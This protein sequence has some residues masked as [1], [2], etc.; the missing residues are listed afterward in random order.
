MSASTTK[1][2]SSIFKHYSSSKEGIAFIRM[3][4]SGLLITANKAISKFGKNNIST[5]DKCAVREDLQELV[6][7]LNNNND[8][9]RKTKRDI[10]QKSNRILKKVQ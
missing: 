3:T 9:D 8:I 4:F 7:L 1:S 5:K 10:V 2:L 6:T